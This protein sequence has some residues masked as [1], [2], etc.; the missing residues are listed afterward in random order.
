MLGALWRRVA[1]P[2]VEGDTADLELWPETPSADVKLSIHIDRHWKQKR[3][4][5]INTWRWMCRFICLI[6]SSSSVNNLY[7]PEQICLDPNTA[8]PFTTEDQKMSACPSH[9]TPLTLLLDHQTMIRS[10]RGSSSGRSLSDLTKGPLE[11]RNVLWWSNEG[12]ALY[13]PFIF[14]TILYISAH[15]LKKRTWLLLCRDN[16]YFFSRECADSIQPL[17]KHRSA[18]HSSSRQ[19][20]DLVGFYSS[21]HFYLCVVGLIRVLFVVCGP[22]ASSVLLCFLLTLR[23]I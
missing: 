3:H 15:H 9:N 5:Q 19:F 1:A 11:D 10:T 14:S 21:Q 23:K 8:E 16:T 18:E 4:K 2:P 22:C 6:K 7:H 12:G 17:Q 13:S 20:K